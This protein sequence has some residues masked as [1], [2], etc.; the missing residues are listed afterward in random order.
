MQKHNIVHFFFYRSVILNLFASQELQ[1][2]EAHPNNPCL[3]TSNTTMLT[4][5]VTP[6]REGSRTMG[7]SEAPPSRLFLPL[8]SWEV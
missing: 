4:T 5:K 6:C 1:T 8:K 7:I 2:T 3:E